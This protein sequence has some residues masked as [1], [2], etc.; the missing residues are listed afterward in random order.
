MTAPS[1]LHWLFKTD[2]GLAARVGFGASVFALLAVVDLMRNGRAAQRWREY[3]FL[4]LATLAGMVYGIANDVATS[5]ISWEYY[6]YGKGLVDMMPE[7]TPPDAAALRTEAMKIGMKAGGSAGILIGAVLLIANN[8][9]AGRRRLGY[10]TIASYAVMIFVVTV[11]FAIL[12]GA[13]GAKGW[14]LWTSSDLAEL[15]RTGDFRPSRFM[16]VYGVHL[17][18]YIGGAIGTMIAVACIAKARVSASDG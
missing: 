4:L 18:A 1:S 15:W 13:V 6:F 3:A 9:R 17:G 5:S 12:F 11:V 2:A 10:G 16:A 14:L 7:K 8:P